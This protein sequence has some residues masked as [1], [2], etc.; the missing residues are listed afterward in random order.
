MSSCAVT[1]GNVA[2]FCCKRTYLVSQIGTHLPPTNGS[3]S[4]SASRCV[5]S[6]L[7]ITLFV[8]MIATGRGCNQTWWLSKCWWEA[9]HRQVKKRPMDESE[10]MQWLLSMSACADTNGSKQKLTSTT[11]MTS[12][13]HI[14]DVTKA[15]KVRWQ[16]MLSCPWVSSRRW[17]VCTRPGS[18]KH[19]NRCLSWCIWLTSSWLGRSPPV[20]CMEVVLARDW[21]N[22]VIDVSHKRWLNVPLTFDCTVSLQHPQPPPVFPSSWVDGPGSRTN[23]TICLICCSGWVWE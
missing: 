3:T 17:S 14:K 1:P 7:D 18:A 5:S 12:D 13:Q 23:W 4:D 9:W 22:C 15:R 2:I 6:K 21:M 16:S 10:R 19:C 8:V 11:F 20:A